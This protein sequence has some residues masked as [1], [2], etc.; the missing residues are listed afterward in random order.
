MKNSLRQEFVVGGWQPGEGGRTGSIGSLLVGYY[1]DDAL[2]YAGKV[3]SGLS[4]ESIARSHRSCS[5]AMRARHEPVR[6]RQAPER[7]ALRR[8]DVVVDVRFTEWTSTGMIRQPTYLGTRTDKDV[9]TRGTRGLSG[10][11]I[12]RPTRVRS[13]NRTAFGSVLLGRKGAWKN[14]LSARISC[15]RSSG[16]DPAV[17][18][19]RG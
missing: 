19:V 13:V 8:A 15:S 7:R 9:R 6:H 12:Q 11:S 4:G 10:R 14:K 17:L 18:G 5:S 2:H 16:A 3:G 1:D